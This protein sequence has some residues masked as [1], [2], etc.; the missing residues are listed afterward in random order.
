MVLR[1]SRT[2]IGLAP[3]PGIVC[4]LEHTFRPWG[5]L[6]S[7][8]WPSVSTPFER[9]IGDQAPQADRSALSMRQAAAI[10]A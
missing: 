9:K 10:A 7:A 8:L 5:A 2:A 6:S 4:P 1:A 3:A